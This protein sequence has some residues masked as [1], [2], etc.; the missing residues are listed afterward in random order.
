MK[1]FEKNLNYALILLGLFLGT[2]PAFA[3]VPDYVKLRSIAF[4][5]S[6]CP[7]GSVAGNVSQD[8]TA[9]TLLFDQYIAEVGPGVPFSEKRKNCQLNIDFDFPQGWSYSLLTLDY[10]GYVSLDPRVT[11]TQQSSYYF[12]G[13]FT[14][15]R[16]RTP[17]VGPI[18]QDY[19]IRDVLGLSSVVWS[20]CGATRSLNINSEIR[21]DNSRNR[22]GRGLMTTDSIDGNVKLIYGIQWRRC[23]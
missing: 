13:Q 9:F 2:V 19:Q 17:M 5:G 12:Q 15:A 23:T 14:T 21:L 16:L 3:D 11:G 20:P 7:A 8:L 22:L 4:A 1:A 6:G 18:D 10:R